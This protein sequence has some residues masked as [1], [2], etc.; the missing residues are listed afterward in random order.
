MITDRNYKFKISCSR[1]GYSSKTEATKCLTAR[2]AKSIGKSPIAFKEENF[3]VDELVKK[4]TNGFAFCYLYDLNPTYKYTTEVTYNGQHS[5]QKQYAYYQRGE[6]KG[7]FKLKYKTL[8]HFYGTQT[9]FVDIDFTNYDD[10]FDYVDSLTYT[11]TA[12]YCS[13]SDNVLKGGVMSRRFRLVYVF[14]EVL[15]IHQ[16]TEISEILYKQILLDTDDIVEDKCWLNANQ[17]YNGGI[18]PEVFKSY[19]VYAINDFISEEESETITDNTEIEWT[20]TTTEDI[21]VNTTFINNL[22]T[23]EPLVFKKKWG[24]TYKY[25]YKTTYTEYTDN[26]YRVTDENYHSLYWNREKIKNGQHRR[27]KLLVRGCTRRLIKPEI[28]V[29]ELIYN[30]YLDREKFIDNSDGVVTNE[31]LIETGIE[32]M[33]KTVEEIKQVV[34]TQKNRPKFVV[35]HT[36]N[37]T[38]RK[39]AVGISRGKITEKI[40]GELIDLNATVNDN[41]KMF[42][43]LGYS[44]KKSTIY[45]FLKKH[46]IKTEKPK[47]L[48]IEDINTNVSIRENLKILKD[49]GVKATFYQVQKIMNTIKPN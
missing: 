42:N 45:N 8:N 44:I 47:T 2:G 38:D 16:F 14:N 24:Y 31:Y 13:Y 4:A 20:E 21:I 25:I 33:K 46:G 30:L 32:I 48:T 18:S 34:P 5:T 36:L 6:N 3:T 9:I 7:Y 1:E 17:Y 10:I 28:T 35:N 49:R 27:H 43:E 12:L 15:N 37:T 22:N 29:E 39:K 23:L 41:L 11:P 40:I 19:M 26:L